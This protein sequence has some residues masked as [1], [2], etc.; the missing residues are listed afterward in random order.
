MYNKTDRAEGRTGR[1]DG[2]TDRADPGGQTGR[3][4]G[5]PPPQ[6][7]GLA[8]MGLDMGVTRCLQ[9]VTGKTGIWH[10]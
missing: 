8:T 1:K 2:R 9:K 7:F 4:E 6:D 3:K 5:P 10:A